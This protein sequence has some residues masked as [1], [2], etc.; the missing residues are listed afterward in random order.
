MGILFVYALYVS[1]KMVSYQNVT[2]QIRQL[3][4]ETLLTKLVSATVMWKWA[5]KDVRKDSIWRAEW[6][7]DNDF[8]L[9]ERT[10]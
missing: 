1:W 7:V 5:S 3:G 9:Y 2:T 8:A 6:S 4:Q 10:T